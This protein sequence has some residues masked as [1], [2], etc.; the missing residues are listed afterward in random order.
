MWAIRV[1]IVDD[2]PVT[3]D[4]LHAA[5]DL[6]NHV[7][8]VGEAD[9]GENA[10]EEAGKLTPD[11]VFMDVRMPGMSGIDAT[12]AILEASPTTKVILIT[13]DESRASIGE[14][15]RAGVSGYLLND[16]SADVLVRTARLVLEAVSSTRPDPP[17][18]PSAASA[19][20]AVPTQQAEDVPVHV[21]KP[22]RRKS[23]STLQVV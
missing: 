21:G 17:P 14:A 10:A 4:R 20:L 23:G 15:L 22:L 19:A 7:V 9:S 11:I 2:N 18:L 6:A 8:V 13:E 16:P 3:R 1:L 5:L 12:K